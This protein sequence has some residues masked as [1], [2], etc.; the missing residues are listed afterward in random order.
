MKVTEETEELFCFEDF[1]TYN[2]LN[3]HGSVLGKVSNEGHVEGHVESPS[4]GASLSTGDFITILQYL[5]FYLSI[6]ILNFVQ[7]N[8][9]EEKDFL[10]FS[11]RYMSSER[12]IRQ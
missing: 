9:H 11:L 3:F 12:N 6:Q 5:N 4:L 7:Y 8:T 1:S 2:S 10:A